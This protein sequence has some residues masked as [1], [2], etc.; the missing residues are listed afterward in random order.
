MS[1]QFNNKD[2]VFEKIL[3]NPTPTRAYV[4][5]EQKRK[6]TYLRPVLALCTLALIIGSIR[7]FNPA[8]FLTADSFN[9]TRGTAETVDNYTATND[10]VISSALEQ[11]KGQESNYSLVSRKIPSTPDGYD[12]TKMTVD[13]NIFEV[14]YKNQSGGFILYTNQNPLNMQPLASAEVDGE[15]VYIVA[16]SITKEEAEKIL[17]S[18]VDN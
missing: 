8:K 7:L 17:S 12:K 10:I 14:W 1:L 2:V 6:I 4:E 15:R 13:G 3:N 11:D 5:P 9:G 18:L 16:D